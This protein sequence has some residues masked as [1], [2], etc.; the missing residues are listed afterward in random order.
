MPGHWRPAGPQRSRGEAHRDER[1]GMGEPHCGER[2]DQDVA[3]GPAA[4]HERE[5]LAAAGTRAQQGERSR[6]GNETKCLI[7]LRERPSLGEG[8]T[9]EV[10]KRRGVALRVVAAGGV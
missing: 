9:P 8:R 5:P 6:C 3:A 2:R 7:A 10:A 1:Q 4:E